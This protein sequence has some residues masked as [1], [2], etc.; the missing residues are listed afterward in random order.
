MTTPNKWVFVIIIALFAYPAQAGN[1]APTDAQIVHFLNRISFGPTAGDI[2]AVRRLGIGEYLE[3]QLHPEFLRYPFSLQ[4]RLSKLPTVNASPTT[5]LDEYLLPNEKAKTLSDDDRKEYERR[6]NDIVDEL[7]EAK[8]LRAVLS[9]AQLQEVMTDFWYNHFNVFAGKD[10]DRL[11][12]SSY[13]RDAIRPYALGKFRDLLQATAHHPAML[14]YL[15]NWLNTDPDSP[16]AHGRKIGINENYAREVMELHTLGV[17]GGYTQQ[18]VT[19][20]AHIL[21]GW[22]L[23]EGKDVAAKAQFYFEPRAHDYN[24]KDFLGYSVQG[25]GE[26][27]IESVLDFL[28]KHPSTAKH[29]AYELAQYFVADDPP[30]SLVTRLAVTFSSSD[31]DIAA[32][33]RTLFHSPEFWDPRYESVKF[34][35][36]FRYIISTLRATYT[37]PSGDTKML[38]GALGNMGEPLYRFLTPNGYANTNDQWLNSDALLKRIDFAKKLAGFLDANS[39]ET[40]ESALG[41]S[42]TTNTLKTVKDADPKQRATLLLSSPEFVYY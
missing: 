21:T 12:V 36:P 7:S 18:D 13:E 6:K 22:G 30:Q 31:G 9:P 32:V 20:L 27:E 16:F 42:W 26:E 37:L 24:A 2:D 40:I 3:K 38:Q 10:L 28:A 25:G 35:P 11:L 34:K 33:L 14:F 39:P 1:G 5:I 23:G 29:I 15:D 41:N 8:I 17:N 4:Q 19:T